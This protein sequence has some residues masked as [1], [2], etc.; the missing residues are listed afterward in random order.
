MN[1]FFVLLLYGQYYFCFVLFYIFCE[2]INSKLSTQTFSELDYWSYFYFDRVRYSNVLFF[3]LFLLL[4]RIVIQK[5]IRIIIYI[6][7]FIFL[8][9]LQSESVPEK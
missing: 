7:R 4:I 3:C 6:F 1:R 8:L 2:R 9:L 5:C